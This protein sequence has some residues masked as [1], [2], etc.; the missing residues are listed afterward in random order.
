MGLLVRRW[1]GWVRF[2][3]REEEREEEEEEQGSALP[4][5]VVVPFRLALA[6][7]RRLEGGWER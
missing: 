7:I 4:P 2:P 6:L 1:G 3:P 5:W